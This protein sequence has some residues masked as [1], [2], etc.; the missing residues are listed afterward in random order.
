[1]GKNSR[2]SLAMGVIT[3]LGV[4]LVGCGNGSDGTDITTILWRDDGNG[5]Y[6]F[7]TNDPNDYEFSFWD[8]LNVDQTPVDTFDLVVKKESGAS[9]V[10]YGVVF[11][12]VDGDNFSR[13]LIT[14]NGSYSI[15]RIENDVPSVVTSANF[16][17]SNGAVDATTGGENRIRIDLDRTNDTLTLTINGTVLESGLAYV[18]LGGSGLGG[19][20]AV[21]DATLENFPAVPVDVRYRTV[22]PIAQP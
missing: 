16:Q 4:V 21:G 1:M 11:D 6:Q 14:L 19:Y 9:T 15:R 12:Y 18:D 13:V 20:A 17:S 22:S 3:L 2:L 10:G 7:S 5:F 8:P